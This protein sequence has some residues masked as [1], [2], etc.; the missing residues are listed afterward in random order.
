M[1]GVAALL[2]AMLF[3]RLG[4]G[5]YFMPNIAATYVLIAGN[6]DWKAG[7]IWQRRA[8]VLVAVAAFFSAS[9]L[10]WAE[11]EIYFSRA[12]GLV[13]GES[14][15]Q[16]VQ[17]ALAR[18]GDSGR[19]FLALDP[20]NTLFP[21]TAYKTTG[22][23]FSAALVIAPPKENFGWGDGNGGA[24]KWSDC[25]VPT[26]FWSWSGR[27]GSRRCAPETKL[28]NDRGISPGSSAGD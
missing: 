28:H 21:L 15:K 19:L 7:T 18:K 9:A 8:L 2:A 25:A 20:V 4:Y 13:W 27:A 16:C 5:W 12:V 23:G 22:C 17:S 3:R 14:E 1:L 26:R 11:S 24:G 6:V 10:S